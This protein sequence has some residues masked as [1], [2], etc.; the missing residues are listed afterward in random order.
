VNQAFVNREAKELAGE[1]VRFSFGENW[2]KFLG[3]VTPEQVAHAQASVKRLTGL[4]SLAGER[5]IDIG[6]GSGLFSLGAI[7]LGAETVASVDIDPN[8]IA[9]AITLRSRI[10]ASADQWSVIKAS[11]LDS[12]AMANLGQA[13]IVYSWGVLHHTGDLWGAVRNTMELVSPGGMLCLALYNH[14]RNEDMH[15]KLKRTYNR[16]PRSVRPVMASA[17]AAARLRTVIM[18]QKRNPIQYIRNYG[19][20]SRGMSFWRDVEDWLGGLPCEFASAE[21]VEAFAKARGFVMEEAVIAPAGA[22]NEYRLRR[23]G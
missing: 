21:D 18:E 4:N 1:E 14:P 16:L 19:E 13:S 9:C 3:H 23:V 5:F 2:S 15:M 17:Y 6:C 8:S 10:G 7:R 12:A 22:N 11:A 20:E